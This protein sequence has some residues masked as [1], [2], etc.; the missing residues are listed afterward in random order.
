[1]LFGDFDDIENYETNHI[2]ATYDTNTLKESLLLTT[3]MIGVVSM[4]TLGLKW[5]AV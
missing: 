1:M 2:A 4:V 5:Y 3:S